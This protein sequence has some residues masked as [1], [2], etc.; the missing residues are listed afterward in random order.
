M[1]VL[2]GDPPKQTSAVDHELLNVL[3]LL[4]FGAESSPQTMIPGQR[5]RPPIQIVARSR[6]MLGGPCGGM[7]DRHTGQ[8]AQAHHHGC[9]RWAGE[10]V[11]A[12]IEHGRRRIRGG[13][14]P[15]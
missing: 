6:N 1:P 5:G 11:M 9:W 14:Q 12:L 7:R 13:L 2:A 8:G 15:C 3:L 4:H 10:L